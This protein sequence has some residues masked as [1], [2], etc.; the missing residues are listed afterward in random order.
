M[1]LINQFMEYTKGAPTADIFRLWSA[2][3]VISAA[4]ERRTWTVTIHEPIYPNMFVLLVGGPGA[5]KT[6]ATSPARKLLRSASRLKIAPD[7]LTKAGFFDAL[8]SAAQKIPLGGQF[9][10]YSCL[11]I[12]ADELGMFMSAYDLDFISALTGVYDGRDGFS[13]QRRHSLGP[14]RKRADIV[15]PLVNILAGSQPGFMTSL[16]P[17]EVWSMGFTARIIL[18]YSGDFQIPKLTFGR[19]G[20]PNARLSLWKDMVKEVSRLSNLHGEFKWEPAA[21]V[22][23]SRWVET[24]A[25]PVQDH[26][27][28]HHYNPKRGVHVAK[29]AMVS[30]AARG[31]DLLITLRD[32]ERGR[33]W[34]LHAESLMPNVF[35]DM[36]G[37]SDKQVLDEVFM[38]LWEQYMRN[39]KPI[40]EN[41]ILH[42]V[43]ER[44]VSNNVERILSL[45]ERMGM[46][47]REAGTKLYIPRPKHMHGME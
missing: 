21:E 27:R 5:G 15:N 13:E 26:S 17:E 8:E 10:E 41:T 7:S 2:I 37:R 38:F 30:S 40:H 33:R 39:K 20:D 42:F 4:M 6:P 29:L 22:E 34:L 45:V 9:V 28:L 14:G 44:T 47:D 46:A 25:A 24:G 3:G 32:L 16:L 36:K 11:S 35:R 19:N 23:M 43:S 31:E 18:I 12:I 1:D